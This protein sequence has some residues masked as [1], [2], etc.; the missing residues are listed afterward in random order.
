[1]SSRTLLKTRLASTSLPCTRDFFVVVLV[2]FLN[3]SCLLLSASTP[4]L[5]HQLAALCSTQPGSIASSTPSSP[6]HSPLHLKTAAGKASLPDIS[7]KDTLFVVAKTQA[8]LQDPY[9]LPGLDTM[10]L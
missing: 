1:M 7:L 4:L 6:P 8:S 3:A 9:F 5:L 2:A 10:S